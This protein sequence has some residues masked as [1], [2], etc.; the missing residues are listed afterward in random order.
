M[1]KTTV[2]FGVILIALGVF[3]YMGAGEGAATGAAT[4]AVES[5]AGD[6]ADAADGTGE[7][8][9]EAGKKSVTALIPAFVG[10]LLAIC[11]LVAFNEGLRMHAMHGAVLVGLL[12][13]LAGAGRGAMGIGKF[14]S[15]DPSLNQRSFLFV[16][17]MA[18][19][20]LVYV[21]LCVQSFI[22]ARK[23][24]QESEATTT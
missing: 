16:W 14:L 3:G 21:V 7:E 4:D 15:G 24:R 10:G 22:Q 9:T 20:C 17:L 8:G 5:A 19:I 1:A 18:I 6:N 11:G 12:G 13:F 2:I 23:R